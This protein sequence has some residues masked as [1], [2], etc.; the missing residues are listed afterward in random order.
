MQM[1]AKLHLDA[2]VNIKV[3]YSSMVARA[4]MMKHIMGE[5]VRW[6]GAFMS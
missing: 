2:P 3:H 5:L 4:P 6:P 1:V